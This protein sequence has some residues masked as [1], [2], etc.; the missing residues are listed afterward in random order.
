M[1]AYK[2]RLKQDGLLKNITLKSPEDIEATLQVLAHAQEAATR[3]AGSPSRSGAAA[4]TTITTITTTSGGRAAGVQ[5]ANGHVVT[6]ERL[7]V[8]LRRKRMLVDH[9][10]G[11]YGAGSSPWAPSHLGAPGPW[12]TAQQIFAKS[13]EYKARRL[14]DDP[15]GGG[16]GRTS[17]GPPVVAAA[18]AA[19]AGRREEAIDYTP[20]YDTVMYARDLLRQ[21]H[22]ADAVAL[23]RLAP[24]QLT[25]MLRAEPP[26][27]LDL[28]LGPIFSLISAAPQGADLRIQMVVKSLVRYLAAASAEM[29]GL[30]PD[31]RAVVGLL[32][33]LSTEDGS[34]LYETAIRARKCMLDLEG[35]TCKSFSLS[36]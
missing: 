4:A 31:L 33:R 2:A 25:Q 12:R 10:A 20:W 9:H 28:I 34:S 26:A 36:F 23:L 3:Q 8:H 6:F 35:V 19:A 15:H 7:A 29:D 16:G 22:F 5:L 18:A 13:W 11:H 21:G 17:Q 32:S 1:K 14:K 27:A 24:A 30:S